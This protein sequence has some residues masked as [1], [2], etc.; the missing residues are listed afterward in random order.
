MAG[1]DVPEAL[2][3][4]RESQLDSHNSVANWLLVHH[5]S[6][7]SQLLQTTTELAFPAQSNVKEIWFQNGD[8]NVSRREAAKEGSENLRMI[9]LE[10]LR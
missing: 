1:E 5:L 8:L 3:W 9:L 10:A 6:A 2:Y 4:S 7:K